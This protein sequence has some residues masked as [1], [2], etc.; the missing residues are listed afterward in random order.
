MT[1]H[2]RVSTASGF[3]SIALILCPCQQMTM[4]CVKMFSPCQVLYG[5]MQVCGQESLRVVLLILCMLEQL[6]YPS[7]RN[8]VL[9]AQS[10]GNLRLECL[11]CGACQVQVHVNCI[12]AGRRGSG[13]RNSRCSTGNSSTKRQDHRS[14]LHLSGR[15]THLILF[16][17]TY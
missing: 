16:Q 17:L 13:S 5:S 11:A 9:C 2:F 7:L 6:L 10:G 15:Q 4:H 12:L 1:P 8:W 14:L 3:V